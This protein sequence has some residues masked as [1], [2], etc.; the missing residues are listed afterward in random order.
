MLAMSFYIIVP[1]L[2]VAGV[3]SFAVYKIVRKR[4]NERHRR[5]PGQSSHCPRYLKC[6]ASKTAQRLRLLSRKPRAL[7]S[8]VLLASWREGDSAALDR[9]LPLIRN[10]LQQLARRHLA[11]ERKATVSSK[12]ASARSVPNTGVADGAAW[13]FQKNG[14]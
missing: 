6:V 9:L 4:N 11:R 14:G 13:T 10:D 8:H 2:G 7:P 12:S 5:K 3:V 1:G